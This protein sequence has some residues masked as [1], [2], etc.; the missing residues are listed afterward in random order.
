MTSTL[1]LIA[2]RL[3]DAVKSAKARTGDKTIGARASNGFIDIVRVAYKASGASS[4]EVVKLGLT[5]DQAIA[6]LSQL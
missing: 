6:A 3:A 2:F 5:P 1:P 4:V